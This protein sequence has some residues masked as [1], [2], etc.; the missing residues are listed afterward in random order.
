MDIIKSLNLDKLINNTEL[1]AVKP[2][3]SMLRKTNHA[4]SDF[5]IVCLVREN[6]HELLTNRLINKQVINTVNC[7][8][9]LIR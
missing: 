1:L 3:G 9:K 2:A 7:L 5:D 6:R 8:S 4:D